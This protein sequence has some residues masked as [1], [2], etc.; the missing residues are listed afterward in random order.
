MFKAQNYYFGYETRPRKA[1]SY[2][3]KSVNKFYTN[4]ETETYSRIQQNTAFM[5]V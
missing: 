4:Y 3:R 5:Q 2:L 1:D